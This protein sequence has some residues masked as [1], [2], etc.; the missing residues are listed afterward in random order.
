MEGDKKWLGSEA[1]DFFDTGK[2]KLIPR[3][4]CINSGGDYVE[5]ILSMYV[6]FVYNTLFLIAYFVN[7]SP[8]VTFRIAILFY[9]LNVNNS[10]LV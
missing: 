6:I 3:Y 9:D 8:D 2:Q 1:E 10:M 4:K 5:N 7:S